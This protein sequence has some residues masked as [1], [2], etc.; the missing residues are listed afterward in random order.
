MK[1]THKFLMILFI[2]TLAVT[3]CQAKATPTT[4]PDEKGTRVIR[5]GT[6]GQ[7]R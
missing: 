1:I 3:A 2:T 4:V 6:G 5:V 7:R